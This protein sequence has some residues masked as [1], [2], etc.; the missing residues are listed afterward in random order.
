MR[1][2]HYISQLKNDDILSDYVRHLTDALKAVADV[3]V[4]TFNSNIQEALDESAPD[5]VHIHGAWDRYAFRLMKTAVGQGYAVVISP[6]GEIGTYAMKHEERLAKS[7]KNA[8]YQR[9]MLKNS[10][11]LLATSNDERAALEALG[12]QKKIDVI[13][14]SI[15]DSTISDRQMAEEMIWFYTKVIDT[16]YRVLMTDSEKEAV[17]SIIHVGMAHDE[18][19]SLLDSDRL[20][21]LRGLKPNEWRRIFLYGDDEDLRQIINTAAE[22]IQLSLPAID[23]SKIS[24]YPTDCPKMMGSLPGDRLVGGNKL[25]ARK[26]R[27]TT[28]DD[29]EDLRQLT[30]M[31]LNARTLLRKRQ[32]SARHLAELYEEIKYVDYDETRFV[33]IT[34]EM[35]LNKFMRRMLQVLADEAYLEEGFMPDKPL[36][37]RSVKQIERQFLK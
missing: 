5:I 22:R 24:R 16:R 11:A 27:E 14:P 30:A 31:L 25:L 10:E 1:I 26:L 7:V 13:G 29:S 17:R 21:T 36:N 19:M 4:A 18:T 3:Y 9:W 2:L 23:T 15:L 34:K 20:L 37:D 32:M 33:E 12:W 8:D 6:H 28:E 35:K